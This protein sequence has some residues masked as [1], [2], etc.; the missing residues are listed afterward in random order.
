MKRSTECGRIHDHPIDSRGKRR[1]INYGLAKLVISYVD[2]GK[3]GCATVLIPTGANIPP[4][5]IATVLD[6]ILRTQHLVWIPDFITRRIQEFAP[7][8]Q[9]A[10][11]GEPFTALMEAA[12]L[13]PYASLTAQVTMIGELEVL[14]ENTHLWRIGAG[15]TAYEADYIINAMTGM[16]INQYQTIPD[17]LL[18]ATSRSPWVISSGIPEDDPIYQMIWRVFM[19]GGTR[20]PN[21]TGTTVEDSIE[22]LLTYYGW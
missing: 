8:V 20:K 14:D 3:D 15:I 7:I 9:G 12:G 17:W 1:M 2:P 13:D 11:I 6:S 22:A 10:I 4:R 18:A 21:I 5:G 16:R 19:A